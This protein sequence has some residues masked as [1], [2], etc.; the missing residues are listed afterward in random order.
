MRLPTSED[1]IDFMLISMALMARMDLARAIERGR[2]RLDQSIVGYVFP[3]VEWACQSCWS[4]GAV[5]VA[6]SLDFATVS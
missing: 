3:L 1:E 6:F 2:R 5:E 4:G